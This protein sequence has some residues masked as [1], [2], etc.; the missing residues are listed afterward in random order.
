[1]KIDH[2]LK[3][4]TFVGVFCF[5]IR[6][7]RLTLLCIIAE[8]QLMRTLY[9]SVSIVIVYREALHSTNQCSEMKHADCGCLE[10]HAYHFYV[11]KANECW[12]V[13]SLNLDIKLNP[14]CTV[15]FSY[16]GNHLT[17]FIDFHYS[18]FWRWVL[19]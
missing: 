11:T 3:R 10:I 4:K 8:V 15:S 1:M 18:W 7:Y 9:K 12:Y 19:Y 2:H 6:L 13:L 17:D 5:S 16:L 14:S